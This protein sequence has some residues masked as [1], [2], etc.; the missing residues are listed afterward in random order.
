MI[1]Q[2]KKV[3]KINSLYFFSQFTRKLYKSSGI[4]AVCR[5]QNTTVRIKNTSLHLDLLTTKDE[6]SYGR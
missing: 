2:T 4:L 6:R 3:K 1:G 5:D